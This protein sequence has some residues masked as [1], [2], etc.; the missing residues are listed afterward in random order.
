[1]HKEF[2]VKIAGSSSTELSIHLK[3]DV[4]IDTKMSFISTIALSG[5]NIKTAYFNYNQFSGK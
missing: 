5:I 1:M 4:A 3:C 2:S